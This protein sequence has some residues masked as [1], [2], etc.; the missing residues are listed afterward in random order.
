M[1]RDRVDQIRDF[2]DEYAHSEWLRLEADPGGR[3]SLEVHRRFLGR[4]VRPGDRVLEIGAGPGRF[5]IQLAQLG[6]QV[7]VTDVSAGQLALNEQYVGD[8]GVASSVIERRL[9]DVR[10]AATTFDA[11]SFDLVVAYGGPL[12]YVFEDA[13]DALAGL[14]RVVRPGRE[15]VGSVMST[16]GAWRALL[17]AVEEEAQ[18]FGDDAMHA[19]LVTGDLRPTQQTGHV[20]QMYRWSQWRDLVVAAG[21]EAF[22]ASASNWASLGHEETIEQIAADPRRWALFLDQEVDACAEVG[23]LDGGTHL[24]F[25]A[26]VHGAA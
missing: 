25:A 13:T 26:R 17:P 21:G 9:L 20:A 14:L 1:S 22:A 16:L 6:A 11:A 2:F 7:V 18:T 10:D 3:V 23:A 8:A 24:L 5:T 4:F 12:S 15:V 19:V